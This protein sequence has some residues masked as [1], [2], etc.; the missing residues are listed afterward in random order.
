ML[1]AVDIGDAFSYLL[2]QIYSGVELYLRIFYD[3]VHLL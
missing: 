3:P 2:T 1:A